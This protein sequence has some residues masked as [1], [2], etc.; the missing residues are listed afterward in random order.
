[1][2]EWLI[3]AETRAANRPQRATSRRYG[4]L[5]EKIVKVLAHME[6]HVDK[7]VSREDLAAVA[8]VGVR[9][10]ERLFLP[11]VGA[12]VARHDLEIRLEGAAQLLRTRLGADVGGGH[13]SS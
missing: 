10:L 13:L 3:R 4:T 8:G 11:E 5:N 1:M 12:T 2:G 7:P 9:Q 6:R